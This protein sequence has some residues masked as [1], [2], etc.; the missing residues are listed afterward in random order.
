MAV[1]RARP[2]IVK[3]RVRSWEAFAR[4]LSLSRGKVWADGPKDLVDYI[5]DLLVVPALA[6]FPVSFS[7]AVRWFSSRTGYENAEELC[8][9]SLFRRA[10][11][12]A[13]VELGDE[14][15]QVKKASP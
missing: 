14:T 13:E 3:L 12:W 6:T 7:G 8:D 1:G 9:D 15:K 10:V 4:W 11:Q 2:G 5:R